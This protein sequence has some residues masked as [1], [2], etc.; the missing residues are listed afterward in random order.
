MTAGPVLCRTC[1]PVCAAGGGRGRVWVGG[2]LVRRAGK[3]LSGE[4]MPGGGPK[5]DPGG[6]AEVSVDREFEHPGDHGSGRSAVSGGEIC[7]VADTFG[8][9]APGWRI[10][11]GRIHAADEGG[12]VSR[13][14]T[15][16]ADAYDRAL[17]RVLL[18]FDIPAELERKRSIAAG[19]AAG[20]ARKV[21][22]A[23]RKAWMQL[24]REHLAYSRRLR[25]ELR[26]ERTDRATG[27]R[28]CG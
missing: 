26:A 20:E 9:A 8:Q 28:M 14:A 25:S 22:V 21:Y 19:M 5:G 3:G 10:W 4:L 23:K 2:G 1:S 6:E 27:G 13:I 7:R 11:N 18:E 24:C 12:L 15:T 17:R 16:Y